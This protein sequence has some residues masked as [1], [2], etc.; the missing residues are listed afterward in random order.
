[1]K[2]VDQVATGCRIAFSLVTVA[3]IVLAAGCGGKQPS[4]KILTD[5][6]IASLDNVITR[7]GVTLDEEVTSDANGSLRVVTPGATTV[8]LFEIEKPDVE[9]ARLIYR[10]KLRTHE[11]SGDVY[12]EMWCRF[13]GKGEFFSRGLHSPLRGTTEWTSQEVYFLLEKGQKPE[14]VKLNLVVGGSGTVWV[15]EVALAAGPRD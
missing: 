11:V 9:D 5:L 4:E 2:E 1:V 3:A 12:L 8:R 10:A 15:D 6:P 14:L 13:R 7:T